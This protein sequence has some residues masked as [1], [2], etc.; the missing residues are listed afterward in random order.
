MHT[1]KIS[2]PKYIFLSPETY[3]SYYKIMKSLDFISQLFIFGPSVS[4]D[5]IISFADVSSVYVNIDSFRH[6][7]FKGKYYFQ[8]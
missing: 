6:L 8:K 1:L 2:K 7:N 4:N 3:K 5:N